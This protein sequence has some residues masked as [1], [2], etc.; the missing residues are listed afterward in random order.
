MRN[1]VWSRHRLLTCLALMSPAL[2]GSPAAVGQEPARAS[3]AVVNR[4]TLPTD[5]IECERI[6]VGEPDDYKPCVALLPNGE[7]L[8]TAFHQYK[9][10]SDKVLEQNLL[11]RSKDGGRA[12]SPPAA[13]DLLGREPYLTVLQDGTLFLTGHLLAQD[14][15]NKQGYTHGYLAGRES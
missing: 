8:L 3:F 13:L 5:K 12:W 15:R 2:L 9:K 1:P 10:D 11:F 4:K 14:V 6:A 7:L